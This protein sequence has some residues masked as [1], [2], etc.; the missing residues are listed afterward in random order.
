MNPQAENLKA[1]VQEKAEAIV[2][3]GHDVRQQISNLVTAGAD[4]LQVDKHGLL[5]LSRSI[6][7]GATAALEKSMPQ[8]PESVLRQVVDGLGDGLSTAALATRLAVD[9]AKAQ[10]KSFASEDLSK[11]T[12]DLHSVRDLFVE[13]VAHAAKRLKSMTGSGL[14]TLRGHAEQTMKRVLP[15]INSTLASIAE[16]PLQFGKESIQAGVKLSRQALGTLFAAVGHRMEE[17]GKR[18]TGEGPAK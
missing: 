14:S 3:L 8:D 6:M 12:A 1:T 2:A 18:L 11:M 17:A 4:Q 15:S 7:D 10:A 5:A 13:T 16:H 9:E